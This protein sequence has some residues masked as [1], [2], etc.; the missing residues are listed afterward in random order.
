MLG[1][2]GMFAAVGVCMLMAAIVAAAGRRR[3]V[4]AT[5]IFRQGVA[6]TPDRA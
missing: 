3:I 2:D 1:P 5:T 4:D 6:R